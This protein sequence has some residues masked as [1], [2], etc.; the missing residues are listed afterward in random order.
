MS[1]TTTELMEGVKLHKI[2][3]KKY[4]TNL[5]AIYLT[6][7]L[8]RKHVTEN[9]LML[10]ILRR[11]TNKLKTQ[12]DINIKELIEENKYNLRMCEEYKNNYIL[13]DGNYDISID[14]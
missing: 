13:I 7:K 5:L 2:D 14:I 12:E 3:T 8:D 11:G 4:K 6:S 1:I 10:A 9:A